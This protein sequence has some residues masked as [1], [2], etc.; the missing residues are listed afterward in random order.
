M[1]I[2]IVYMRKTF[3]LMNIIKRFFVIV[4]IGAG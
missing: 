4:I 1:V 3:S 2:L